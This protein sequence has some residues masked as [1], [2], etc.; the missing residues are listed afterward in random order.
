LLAPAGL[1]VLVSAPVA[2]PAPVV[3]LGT[4]PVE[5]GPDGAVLGDAP[6]GEDEGTFVWAEAVAAVR[7]AAEAKI[8]SL[9]MVMSR[10]LGAQGVPR[11]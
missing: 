11:P 5:A 4:V 10:L 2:A 9:T 1:F 6:G 7:S 8:A 3:V